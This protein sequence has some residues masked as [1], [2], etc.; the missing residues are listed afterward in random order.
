LPETTPD[1]WEYRGRRYLLRAVLADDYRQQMR[2]RS[3]KWDTV[4]LPRAVYR[5]L[6]MPFSRLAR[7]QPRLTAAT[8]EMLS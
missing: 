1:L 4:H 6:A 2:V 3:P 7:P 5:D 8:S